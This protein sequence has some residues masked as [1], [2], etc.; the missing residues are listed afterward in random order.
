MLKYLHWQSI[1][2]KF[3]LIYLCLATNSFL[4]LNFFLAVDAMN[5]DGSLLVGLVC[6]R[7]WIFRR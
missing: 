6:L 5:A 7:D 1:K 4:F 2:I 3:E